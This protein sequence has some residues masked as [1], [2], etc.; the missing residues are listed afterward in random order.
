MRAGGK[1]EKEKVLREAQTSAAEIEP[2][3]SRGWSNKEHECE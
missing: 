3:I 1:E 2:I